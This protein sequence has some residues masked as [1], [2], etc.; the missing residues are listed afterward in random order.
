MTPSASAKRRT[1]SIG[2]ATFDLFVSTNKEV[3]HDA[4]GEAFV[5]PLGQK[6]WMTGVNG[7]Y[8]G[9]A[10][11]T[12]VGLSRLG[13]DAGFCGIVSDDQWGGQIVE[14]LKKEN[15]NTE[16]LTIVEGESSS[17]SIIL[18]SPSGE[19]VILAHQG[20]AR[21]LHDVT[22]DRETAGKMD[23]VYLNHIHSDS[24]VIEDDIIDILV[25]A[26]RPGI[27][28]NPG[29]CQ[30]DAGLRAKNNKLLVSHCTLLLLNKEEAIAFT[31]KPDQ[32]Y[33]LR[34]LSH[35]GAG[36][37]VISDGKRGC[38]ATDGKSLY[39]CPALSGNVVDT[40]GAGD[41]FGTGM[42]WALCTGKDLPGALKAGTI[43]A[44]SVVGAVGAQPGLL[45][46]TEMQS[47]LETTEI[48]IDIVPL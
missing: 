30:I 38:I 14:N 42:T 35:E 23:W 24:C 48:D 40:T 4:H 33:A 1:I 6:I 34:L 31:G 47:R 7:C 5:L 3:T 43:N 22:F 15:V 9:G 18:S 8:G 36:I 26:D 2:G 41:A 19:R 29:G 21:H 44:L 11:N 20:T 17:F 10:A 16:S 27:T 32:E 39:R 45:T 46:D 25:A 12:S 28:W 13:L 37:V